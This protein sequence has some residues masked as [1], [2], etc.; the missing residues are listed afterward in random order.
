MDQLVSVDKQALQ[1][2]SIFGQ[3]FTLDALRHVVELPDYDCAGLAQ[4]FLVRPVDDGF[5]FA[6]ALIRDA[7]YDSLLRV[8]RRSFH[9]RAAEW[10]EERDL[11]LRAEHLDRAEDPAAPRAYLEAARAQATD[12]RYERARTLIE[13]GLALAS[14]IA[15]RFALTCLQGDILHD[16]GAMTE[17]RAAYER[18]LEAAADDGE[19][20]RAWLGLA[21]VKRVT[22]DLDGAFADL[23][24]AQAAAERHGL[25]EQRARIHFLRG[26]LH[27]PRGDIEGCLAEHQKSLELAR[28]DRLCP[29]SKR[30]HSAASAMPNT[31][32]GRLI[33]A[34]RHFQACVDLADRHGLGRIEV[35]NRPM[36]ATRGG[37]RKASDQALEDALAAVAAAVR[38]GHGRAEMNRPP[39]GAFLPPCPWA[40]PAGLGRTSSRR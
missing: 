4:R 36:A 34:Y 40:T 22:D 3:R 20:V 18:A 14:Q 6:H 39:R 1:A 37:T 28:A 32:R 27:F 12:Y 33:C 7:V 15:D 19:R 2:A 25:L 13:R 31:L 5:L 16:L 8:R 35:A 30:R 29:N 24:R 10:F 23:E 38:V 11:I 9:R 17:S 21:A 26:N